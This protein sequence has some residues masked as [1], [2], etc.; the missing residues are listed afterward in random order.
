M[1]AVVNCTYVIHNSF[2]HVRIKPDSG[3]NAGAFSKNAAP[4]E[5]TDVGGRSDIW[6]AFLAAGNALTLAGD[7]HRDV[8]LLRAL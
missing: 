3:E 8:I 2:I 1:G 4:M 5:K 7:R 6:S